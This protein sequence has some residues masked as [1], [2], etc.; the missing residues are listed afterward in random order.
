MVEHYADLMTKGRSGRMPWVE[1]CVDFAVLGLED[2][3]GKTPT[4][5]RAGETWREARAEVKAAAARAEAATRSA[6]PVH[7][8]RRQPDWQP[9]LTS[10]SESSPR[11][12][13]TIRSDDL[14]EEVAPPRRPVEAPAQAAPGAAKPMTIEDL[15]PEAR[16]QI[17]RLRQDFAET[18]RK[19]FGRF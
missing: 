5:K 1:L 7:R 4:P 8:T 13:P 19:R 2:G 16:A 12:V 11:P 10:P 3:R 14:D 18:D 17:E 9:P 6:P 15:N